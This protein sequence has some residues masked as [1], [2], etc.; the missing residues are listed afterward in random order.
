MMHGCW[1]L[2]LLV[3]AQVALAGDSCV[4]ITSDS[5][6]IYFG[7]L[8]TTGV[9]GG[10]DVPTDSY[11]SFASLATAISALTVTDSSSISHTLTVTYDNAANTITFDVSSATGGWWISNTLSAGF[12][13]AIGH[14][15]TSGVLTRNLPTT[16]TLSVICGL[17][18]ATPIPA[19]TATPIP[20]PTATPI[21]AP[22]ATS[23][24]APT[25]T[26]IPAP[27]TS[28]IPAPTP[29]PI[30]SPTSALS[31]TFS[32]YTAT[33]APGVTATVALD[34]HFNEASGITCKLMDSAG[35]SM[36]A[37]T[38]TDSLEMI[39]SGSTTIE[40][41][42]Y[43]PLAMGASCTDYKYSCW[44]YPGGSSTPYADRTVTV[45]TGLVVCG[46]TNAPTPAPTSVPL[47]TPTSVPIPAPTA[48]P[49]PAP[50]SAPI[51]A[52]TAAPIP[53]PTAAPIPSPTAAP[54][55]APTAVP[56]PAPTALPLPAPTTMPLP[57]PTATPIP[58]P[59][60][61]APTPATNLAI[62]NYTATVTP[63]AMA[64]VHVEYHFNEAS[65]VTC[66]FADSAGGAMSDYVA[67]DSLALL[68]HGAATLALTVKDTFT[69]GASCTDYKYTCYSY[70]GSSSSPFADNTAL[71]TTGTPSVCAEYFLP[72]PAPSATPTPVPLPAPTDVPLPAPT[73]MP[74]PTPTAAPITAPTSAAP[75]VLAS[76][77]MASFSGSVVAGDTASIVLDFVLN[78]A[79]AITCK[80]VD[81]SN[82]LASAYGQ[83]T[84]L[85]LSGS[86]STTVELAVSTPL[87]TGAG[88]SYKFS[89]WSYPGDS[90][91]SWADRTATA[92]T[93]NEVCGVTAAPTSAPT[94]SFAPTPRPTR[95]PT[96]AP[97]FT[98]APTVWRNYFF[99][100]A[101]A[102]DDANDG[103]SRA[104]PFASITAA[105]AAAGDNTTIY[106]ADGTYTNNNYGKG[107]VGNGAAVT[108]SNA[109]GL[110]LTALAG[111]KPKIA[112]DGSGGIS[113]IGDYLEVSGF[114]V[115]GPNA[116][117]TYDEA[118]ADRL[119][120]SNKYSGRGI[121]VW[122]GT[123]IWIHHNVVHDT[124]NSGIRVNYGDYVTVEDNH[125]YNC[126]FWS[127]NAESAVVY[128]DS[129]S[130]DNLDVVK[131][132]IRRNNVHD[133]VN[134]IP[135]YNENYD[136]PQY[137]IVRF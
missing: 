13:A 125:I 69:M 52:P 33:V 8:D 55:P 61:A 128:A 110:T 22:T 43:T 34:Y 109:Y 15:T 73:A 134:K 85:E 46:E 60:T 78:G 106:V 14:N 89:C 35:V 126:T 77:S 23:I 17:P 80:L 74:L 107:R 84:S 117:I 96:A 93:A 76:L 113:M 123:H 104:A 37:N 20:A 27:T 116:D 122:G 68:G 53:A 21:P 26:P 66:K 127:S 121:C 32:S 111:H 58:A 95:V 30:P 11:T 54:I 100:D 45:V 136:D 120:H 135:Y 114:E 16:S 4:D 28:P 129:T 124:P 38:A 88:C 79:S 51:L 3:S 62:V 2:L 1:G 65:G 25:A 81:A 101:A 29:V 5:S 119:I 90:T 112:F 57:A 64:A 105:V 40:L 50:T 94:R 97:T 71:V 42:V 56:I 19:P 115:A 67:T 87:V 133:N 131:M 91:S 130:I 41:T 99:V 10:V 7:K 132:V 102:G 86:G 103:R 36:S 59:T 83:T 108:I 92:T 24:P 137:L 82:N 6:Y 72:S 118:Y 75:T 48:V 18:T 49:I 47:P 70:P 98:V 9:T 44:S 12:L 39:G 31:L 63:G